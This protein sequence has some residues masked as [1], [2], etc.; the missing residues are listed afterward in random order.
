MPI[1]YR[2]DS[3]GCYYQY[4]NHGTKYYVRDQTGKTRNEKLDKAYEKARKQT[5]AIHISRGY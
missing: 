5:A 4:G 1:H 2:K 3:Y